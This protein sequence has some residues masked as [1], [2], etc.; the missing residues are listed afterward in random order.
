MRAIDTDV[1]VR[2]LIRDDRA[3]AEAADRFVAAG[4][5]VPILAVAEAG[6]ML[7]SVY[8]R[9][10][11][12]LAASIRMLL[13]HQH[14]T[15]QDPEVVEAALATFSAKPRV[16]F[17]DALLLELARKAGHLP[18]GTFDQHVGRLEGAEKL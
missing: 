15:L 8:G 1:L 16:G 17:S 14:L 2:L 10:A 9:S 12:E 7:T 3:Q 6:W 5:W 18:L 4:A 13:D 11:A